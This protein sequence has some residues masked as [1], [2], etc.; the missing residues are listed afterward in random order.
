MANIEKDLTGHR[1]LTFL[2][3]GDSY[4]I[5]ESVS[6][7]ENFP[8]QVALLLRK[9]GFKIADPHIIAKTGWTTNELADAILKENITTT[10]DLVTLL[11]GV[12][13]QY[14]NESIEVYQNQFEGLLK[15]A[16]QFAGNKKEHVI[17]LSIPDWGA[18]PY[19]ENRDRKQ[20][21]KKINEFNICN[22][23]IA[24]SLG[25]HYINITAGS[26]LSITDKSLIA[27][28]GLHPSG[29]EYTRWA[30]QVVTIFFSHFHP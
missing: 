22:K 26:H 9:K 20:I 5:G 3:L 11:I 21:T 25:I 29:K 10:Y 23:Q 19:A 18:T 2:A 17:V 12:N 30:S 1:L 28:D 13:N 7:K 6:P 8:S 24:D 27:S 4:T 15:S 16:I 14:R